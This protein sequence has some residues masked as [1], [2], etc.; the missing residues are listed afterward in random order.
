LWR[1]FHTAIVIVTVAV[2]HCIV[3]YCL[4]VC[5]F[6]IFYL[7]YDQVEYLMIDVYILYFWLWNFI[8][9]A[10]VPFFFF[11][12][13][14]WMCKLADGWCKQANRYFINVTGNNLPMFFIVFLR[15]THDWWLNR[16]STNRRCA[17]VNIYNNS[18]DVIQNCTI[19]C[20]STHAMRALELSVSCRRAPL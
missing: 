3:M 6:F 19:N 1:N 20:S 5:C 13:R 8:D 10:I 4:F 18:Y 7:Y 11:T 12:H 16:R 9:V 2:L 17:C 15:N 14:C